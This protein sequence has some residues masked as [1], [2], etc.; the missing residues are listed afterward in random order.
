VPDLLAAPTLSISSASDYVVSWSPAT[1]GQNRTLSLELQGVKSAPMSSVMVACAGHDSD[2]S[3][4]VPSAAL[5]PLVE[6]IANVL[7]LVPGLVVEPAPV[8]GG[9]TVCRSGRPRPWRSTR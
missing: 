2:G 7:L 6:D 9:S 8:S 1:D 5:A 3:I 4:T